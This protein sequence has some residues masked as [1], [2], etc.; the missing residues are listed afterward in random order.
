M[1]LS[2]DWGGAARGTRPTSLPS[3]LPP[4]CRAGSLQLNLRIRGPF[5]RLL[6]VQAVDIY[7]IRLGSVSAFPSR[8]TS[9]IIQLGGYK[10][11]I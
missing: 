1:S 5:N 4:R 2:G 10:E 7:T 3:C 9:R 6:E 8:R 11:A